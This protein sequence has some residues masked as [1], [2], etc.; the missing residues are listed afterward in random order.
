MFKDAWDQRTQQAE[1]LKKDIAK[2]LKAVAAQSN[3]LMSRLIET[4]TPTG[5]TGY[6]TKLA[7][8]EAHRL[9]L[10]EQVAQIAA[11][12][13]RFEEQLELSPTFLANPYK[14]WETATYTLRRT[15]LEL[16][17]IPPLS[18]TTKHNFEHWKYRFCSR[19]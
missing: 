14:A 5:V 19:H 6:D 18:T 13:H 17:L 8:L 4:D 1:L 9:L 16:V 10:A 2:K 11:P 7:K 15:I 3:K 12:A